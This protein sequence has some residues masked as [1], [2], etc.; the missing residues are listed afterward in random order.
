M[1]KYGDL[2]S[3]QLEELVV[4]KCGSINWVDICKQTKF[5]NWLTALSLGLNWREKIEKA[6]N[7]DESLLRI[8]LFNIDYF[9]R[10]TPSTVL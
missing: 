9:P 1:N 3:K 4:K 10:T 5:D 2:N 6:E 7:K 8:A